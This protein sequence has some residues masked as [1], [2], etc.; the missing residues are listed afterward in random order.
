MRSFNWFFNSLN[1]VLI[2]INIDS[3][4]VMRGLCAAFQ[5]I[6]YTYYVDFLLNYLLGD[7]ILICSYLMVLIL[8]GQVNNLISLGGPHAG[9]ASVPLCGVSAPFCRD[10]K[11]KGVYSLVASDHT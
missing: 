4:M 10:I 5:N 7:L 9:T 6:T 2:Q 3:N 8:S 11:F 1:N